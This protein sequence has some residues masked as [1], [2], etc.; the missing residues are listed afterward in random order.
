[1]R[2]VRAGTGAGEASTPP[3]PSQSVN[4]H[5]TATSSIPRGGFAA[6]MAFA[7]ASVVYGALE[8]LLWS[9]TLWGAHF[10]A[11][12]PRIVLAVAAP[13]ALIAIAFAW[14]LPDPLHED[15]LPA[16]P[17]ARWPLAIG[18]ALVAGVLFWA[19][20][21]RHLFWGDALPL[22]INIPKG[23]AFHPDE[24]LTLFIHQVLYRL[25][26]G[27]WS[28]VT[29]VAIGSVLAGM[30]FT[31]WAV[32]WLSARLSDRITVVAAAAV[33][34]AQGF[35]TLFFG[36]VENYSYLAVAL[37]VFFTTGVDFIEGR[38][39]PFPP[40]IAAVAAYGLHILGGVTLAP[41][42]VLV[43]Y[44]L[45]RPGQRART[46]AAALTALGLLLIASA[47]TAHLYPQGRS[48]VS[49]ILSGAT[50]ILGN[51]SLRAPSLLDA[52]HWA[53][54][55]SQLQLVGPLSLPWLGVVVIGVWSAG[56]V[57]T[58]KAAFLLI[59]A[60]ALLGPRLL[61]G[62]G[63]LG[64]ARDW[65]IFAAPSLVA[66][67]AGLTLA[68]DVVDEARARRL[69]FALLA[70]SLF[71]TVPWIALNT[72]V[73][74]TMARV[75]RL[76][77]TH[78]R[79]ETMIGTYYLNGGDLA[80]AERWFK[81]AIGADPANSNSQSGLGLA[82]AR[83][84][85]LEE[86]VGPMVAAVRLR[87]NVVAYQDDLISLFLAL[88]RWDQAA[89]TLRLRLKSEPAHVPSWLMLAQCAERSGNPRGAES[90]LEEARG[91]LGD[92]PGIAAALAD[93]RAR[94]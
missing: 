57:R 42:A 55:W 47:A 2:R 28:G 67:L 49:G 88:E 86:A 79:G 75:E 94:R 33:L 48:L 82:L 8:S 4:P 43:A 93:L 85:R 53:N 77:L 24:P 78:G 15:A 66:P 7:A 14:R 10:Y 40:M 32:R 5:Q 30:A 68:L 37:L 89:S 23:Q 64:T 59:G 20:R 87:P 26:G 62:E 12:F 52:H 50:K 46:A 83:Q 31:A 13:T 56:A 71:H 27:R 11:F 73:D 18:A 51:S 21:D 70:A 3:A 36:H 35:A 45:W 63:A 69:V 38:G 41:A 29:A 91:V 72:S 61:M 90:I 58:A 39:G 60:A 22:S 74:R 92:D 65:D 25:G 81:L 19:F 84:N 16:T 17:G 6:L 76:P 9:G 1:M 80:K 44:G 54:V 34:L